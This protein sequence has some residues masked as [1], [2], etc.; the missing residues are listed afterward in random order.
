MALVTTTLETAL[1]AAFLAMNSMSDGGDAYCADKMSAAIKAFI[2]T[3]QVTTT[4]TGAAPAGSYSGAGVGT[5]TIDADSLKSDLQSTF[6]AKYSNND[7]AAHMATDIDS[8]CKADKTVK[9]TSTGTVTIPA[10]GTIPFSGPGE[11]KFT[12]TKSS[13][14]TTLKACFSAMDNMATGGNQYYAAQ[15]ASAVNSYLKAGAI[16]V[17]LKS[18]FISGSGSGVIA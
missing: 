16:S 18:P 3:G 6:Q 10:G 4:D 17:T 11:G 8:A 7:L 9:T 15:L 5:M 12:G 2:L 14:E 13:I 1:L